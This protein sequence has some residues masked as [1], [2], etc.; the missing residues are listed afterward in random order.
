MYTISI[1]PSALKEI[2]KLPKPIIKKVENAIDNLAANPRPDGVKKLKGTT[3]NLYRI[4]IGNYR[5]VYIID[6]VIRIVNISRVGHRRDIYR[7]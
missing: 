6:D 2:S 4:R 5:I 7:V 1:K 3:E